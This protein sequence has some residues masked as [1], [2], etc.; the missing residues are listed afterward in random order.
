M[1]IYINTDL[2]GICAFVDWQEAQMKNGRGIAYTKEFLTNEVNA[3][4]D[5]IYEADKNAEIVIQDGHMGGYW[6][7]NLIVEK[8]NK[9]ASVIQG[10]RGVE[11]AG[12]DS[13]F[14]LMFA[15]GAHSMAGTFY[16]V[17]DHTIDFDNYYNFWI[18]D[19]KVGEIGIW[20]ALAGEYG[21]P[22][23]FVSG[24]Y[25]AVE[26]AKALLGDIEGV[27]VKK[28]I[29]RYTAECIHPEMAVNMIKDAAKRAVLRR[30]EYK[31]FKIDSPVNVRIE[32][33][34]TFAAYMAEAK[35][36]GERI[37]SRMV[38]F[39]GSSVDEVMKLQ[40]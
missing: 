27:A 8:L 40:A 37:E 3:A 18:N 9:H 15:I 16:G 38:L 33:T 19:I 1:K 13:S 12:L 25:W 21:V 14:D 11:I 29:N 17:M 24:D 39:R 4:I 34:N 28:G 32:Y 31:P 7:P 23:A 26:E 30:I 6:G 2:E 20:A 36:R 5:G 10:K 22:L 35:G